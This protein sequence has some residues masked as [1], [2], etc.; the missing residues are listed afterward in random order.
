M[1]PHQ[2][3]PHDQNSKSVVSVYEKGNRP[4]DEIL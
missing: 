1:E 2:K 3:T 4:T